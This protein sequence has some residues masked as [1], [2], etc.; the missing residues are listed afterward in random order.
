MNIDSLR[1]EIIGSNTFFNTPY[2]KRL[3]TYADYTASGKTLRFI[4]KYLI[5][6]QEVYANTHTIDSFTGKTTTA[7]LQ[8]A[9]DNIKKYIGAN[10]NNYLIP[11]G[12][13]ATG[14]I[15]KLCD[16]LGLY[17]SPGLRKSIDK[18]VEELKSNPNNIKIINEIFKYINK[19][20]PIIFVSPYEH[21]SN[22]LIWKESLAD[23]EEINLT[24]DGEFDYQDLE[25]KLSKYPNRLKIGSFS[26]ASNVTGIKTDVYK[27]AKI[28]HKHHGLVF[29][30]FA[31]S[32]PYV[33][34]NMNKDKESYFD[35]IFISP[36]KFIGGPGS[37]GILVI[38]KKLYN[39]SY[40]PTVCGG[41]T[42]EFVSPYCYEFLE[43]VETRESAGTPGILQ[44]I[45]AS[46]A[47]E[48]K[49]YIGINN[50]MKIEEEMLEYALNKLSQDDNLI[51][52]GPKDVSRRI[53]ILSFNIKHH[54]KLL[55]HRFVSK[56]LNDLF[57]IQ[58]RAGCVCAG[59]YA[60]RILGICQTKSNQLKK[61]IKVTESLRPGFV[62]VN[63]HY[64]MSKEEVNFIIDAI[65]FISRYGALFLTQYKVNLSTGEWK[66]NYIKEYN[67]FI[68]N[69]GLQASLENTIDNYSCHT[70]DKS[71]EYQSYLEIA[72]R[73]ANTIK[74]NISRYKKYEKEELELLRWFNF[75]H[76]NNN[77]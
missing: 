45:K 48:F 17:I 59:P 25:N 3:I 9:Q 30:D 1:Q 39:K 10:E 69:F 11:I 34:I 66:H 44:I 58:S 57:G 68:D 67:S 65:E 7:I 14:A 4:E 73:V 8:K 75:I 47:L 70:I 38:N 62:R 18:S 74:T 61:A 55:H 46:L 35:A 24:E 21:H 56:L 43:D 40:P 41:G 33:E 22:Y 19:I 53:S 64:L 32:A 12:T 37:S 26:A 54:D 27:V 6:I 60:H 28:M 50:I 5:K 77:L 52:Y 42:V 36:H 16:I 15:K 71:K 72:K 13:G 29:L 51:I 63:F 76:T 2:G 31:A 23:V 20:R 49:E